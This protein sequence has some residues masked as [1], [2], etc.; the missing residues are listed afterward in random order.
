MI[1]SVALRKEIIVT[2]V[3]KIGVL[4]DMSK[5]VSGH[6]IN[7]EA[8]LGYALPDNTAKIVLV[9][10]KNKEAIEAL[11]KQSYTSIEEKDVIAV[12]LENKPGV[13]K[14]ITAKLAAD[15]I[16]IQKVYGTVCSK[17]CPALLI[18]STSNNAG[19]LAALQK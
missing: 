13:L 3:N 8:V 11:H 15:N 2:V 1:K 7:I 10:D 17:G 4:A 19:A 14:Q 5:I 6:G 16:D 12:E 9:T 18:L